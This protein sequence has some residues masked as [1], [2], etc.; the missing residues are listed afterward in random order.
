VTRRDIFDALRDKEVVFYGRL[1]EIDFLQRLYDLEKTGSSDRRFKNAAA[2][3]V[4]HRYNNND[5]DDDWVY[6]DERFGL[7]DGDDELL[8]DFLCEMVHP[9]VR[10]D[11]QEVTELVTTF[12]RLLAPDG[13]ELFESER[14]SGRP[15][16]RVRQRMTRKRPST[17]AAVASLAQAAFCPFGQQEVNWPFFNSPTLPLFPTRPLVRPIS[18][19]ISKDH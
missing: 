13:W 4:Q 2:E 18:G 17:T 8:L 3:I 10:S 11:K 6:E 14:I 1:D 12:N 19:D 5:W 7:L 9:E 16:Y 15:V